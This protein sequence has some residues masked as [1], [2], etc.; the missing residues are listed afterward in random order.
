[1]LFFFFFLFFSLVFFFL[2]FFVRALFFKADTFQS[3]CVEAGGIC[4][5]ALLNGAE[6]NAARLETLAQLQSGRESSDA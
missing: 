4:L 3:H 2:L 5:V 6:D 1:L